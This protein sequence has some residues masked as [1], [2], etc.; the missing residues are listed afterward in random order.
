MAILDSLPRAGKMGVKSGMLSLERF[1][2]LLRRLF[3]TLFELVY[4]HCCCCCCCC[5]CFCCLFSTFNSGGMLVAVLLVCA[6]ISL[7]FLLF[8]DSSASSHE[9]MICECEELDDR[10]VTRTLPCAAATCGLS[11]PKKAAFSLRMLS[12][13]ETSHRCLSLSAS[14]RR[15]SPTCARSLRKTFDLLCVDEK[16]EDDNF[17]E[18]EK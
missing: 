14:Q 8:F 6:R 15:S 5:C 13:H 3:V 11:T 2:R 17:L 1:S 9:R 7:F 16:E 4:C 12:A 10:S 18:N